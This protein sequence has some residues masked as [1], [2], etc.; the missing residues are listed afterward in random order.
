MKILWQ[1]FTPGKKLALPMNSCYTKQNLRRSAMLLAIGSAL[2][3]LIMLAC[4]VLANALPVGGLN[5][6][7]VSGL[8]PNYFVPAGYVFSIWSIIYLLLGA[9]V[10]SR[11]FKTELA[12]PCAK[13]LNL[14]FIISSLANAG[15]IFAWHHLYIG[16]SMLIMVVILIS[17]MVIYRELA[18]IP[19][20][21][22]Q[23]VYTRLP[24]QIYLGWISVATI[25][26][27][28]A[29]LVALK[30]GGFGMPEPLWAA[31]MVLIAG[32]LGAY[33]H[34]RFKDYAFALVV[35]W[36]VAGIFV[37]QQVLPETADTLL[38]ITTAMVAGGLALTLILKIF[39]PALNRQKA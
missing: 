1:P 34:H 21:K 30:W 33:M 26:N 37:R 35:V 7:Q 32:M 12:A 15:W 19:M 2:A 23:A 22:N 31:I 4:N 6:G 27:M 18:G 10:V 36:A 14:W 25:A 17:L 16:L 24:F 5:T 28:T 11:F 39:L 13:R 8:Y 20:K 29:L 38:R 3:Y 9:F